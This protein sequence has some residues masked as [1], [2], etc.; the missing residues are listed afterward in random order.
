MRMRSAAPARSAT[1]STICSVATAPSSRRSL[2]AGGRPRALEPLQPIRKRGAGGG[3]QPGDAGGDER[4]KKPEGED[5]PADVDGIGAR[6]RLSGDR[7]EQPDD[8]GGEARAERGAGE[9]EDEAFGQRLA[10]QPPSARAERR[11]HRVLR[12]P[13]Q[14]A[15]Q[16]QA[17]D[18]GAGD[19]ED[20][21]HRSEQRHQQTPAV[22]IEDVLHRHDGAP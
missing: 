3:Q 10:E 7:L 5:R 1:V 9:R 17:R 4:G 13:L 11:A 15:R 14:P 18:V 21:R 19:E 20:E 22:A 6:H 8:A 2:P 16:E 12:V